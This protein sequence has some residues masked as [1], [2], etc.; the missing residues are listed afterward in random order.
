MP[1]MD[2]A[3][4]LTEFGWCP[5][6]NLTGQPCPLC[7]G[8]RAVFSLLRGD[9]EAALKFNAVVAGLAV[10]VLARVCW[11]LVRERSQLFP[12]RL[13]WPVVRRSLTVPLSF[14]LLGL[15]LWWAWNLGR[16]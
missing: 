14:E 2:V 12:A 4:N 1:V 5:F 10:L 9:P 13:A 7:G 8:T 16:W 11:T 3:P 15:T 6:A